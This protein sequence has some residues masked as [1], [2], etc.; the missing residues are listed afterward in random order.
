MLIS[1]LSLFL[2]R[3]FRLTF[4]WYLC[5]G[6]IDAVERVRCLH[7]LVFTRLSTDPDSIFI[8]GSLPLCSSFGNDFLQYVEIWGD[9]A[10]LC[11]EFQGLNV[12]KFSF[13]WDIIDL[14]IYLFMKNINTVQQPSNLCTLLPWGSFSR[15]RLMISAG[16]NWQNWE[17]VIFLLH[18]SKTVGT[19]LRLLNSY[20]TLLECLWFAFSFDVPCCKTDFK[21]S[22][23]NILVSLM[24]ALKEEWRSCALI[25][26]EKVVLEIKWAFVEQEFFIEGRSFSSVIPFF[27]RFYLMFSRLPLII[28]L[29]SVFFNLIVERRFLMF[30]LSSSIFRSIF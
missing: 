28:L 6:V 22:L 4:S 23:K 29:S 11:F 1:L 26:L 9:S 15:I 12:Y 17:Y 30:C 27:N 20:T 3:S 25:F 10:S 16:V 24:G 7:L 5:K 21:Q 14:I 8:L 19:E 13:R 18:N 2:V